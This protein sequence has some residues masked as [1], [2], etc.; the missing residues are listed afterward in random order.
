MSLAGGPTA[1]SSA[2][3]PG[4]VL[5]AM[6]DAAWPRILAT[7]I[8]NAWTYAGDNVAPGQL[9]LDRLLNEFRFRI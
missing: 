5:I 4:R 2:G 1:S 8:G 6:G 7:R 9:S 3:A